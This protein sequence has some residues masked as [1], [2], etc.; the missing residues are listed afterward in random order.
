MGRMTYLNDVE[1]EPNTVLTVG[2]FDGVHQGHRTLIETVVKKAQ[3][4]NARSV[5]VTFDPHPREII[6]PGNPSVRLLTTLEERCELMTDIGVDLMVVIPFNRDFSLL[7]SEE[8]V[9]DVVFNKI[10]IKEFVIGYDHHFGR[11]REGTIET[12]K[13]MGTNLGFNA[14]V[15]SKKEVGETTVSSS[16]IRKMINEKGDVEE[17]AKLLGRFYILNGTVVHGNKR[18]KG[19]GFPT[20]NIKPDHQRKV[21]PK[22][23]VYAVKVRINGQIFNGMMNVG[24]R[25]TFSEGYERTLEVH[26]F[27]FS[28]EIYGKPIQVRFITR[29]RDEIKFEGKEQLIQQLNKDKSVAKEILKS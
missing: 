10:G 29:I 3:E 17:A 15:V 23:G 13:E 2:T 26:I 6:T 24:I 9:E 16:K 12:V 7:S 22:V 1:R 11:D 5:I 27:D 20:A 14:H 18:G 8:F 21:V 25:P 28:D 19:L 4:Q